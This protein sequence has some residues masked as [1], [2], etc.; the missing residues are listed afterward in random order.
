MREGEH[1]KDPRLDKRIILKFMFKKWD[2]GMDWINLAQDMVRWQ[3]V[4]NV[5]MHLWVP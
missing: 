5:V 3:A 2:G 1:L 4:V